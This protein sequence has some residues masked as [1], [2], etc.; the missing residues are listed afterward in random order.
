MSQKTRMF[1]S[2]IT[3]FILILPLINCLC[4]IAASSENSGNTVSKTVTSII[5]ILIFIIVSVF[6]AILTFKIRKNKSASSKNT[7]LNSDTPNTHIKNQ[8]E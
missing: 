3:S 2:V 4:A 7:D 6:S 8:E 5:F 1:F